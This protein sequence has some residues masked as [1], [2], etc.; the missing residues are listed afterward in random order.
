MPA[1]KLMPRD[2][3]VC[4]WAA[5][6]DAECGGTRLDASRGGASSNQLKLVVAG[7]CRSPAL[8]LPTRYLYSDQDPVIL[9][10]ARA[11]RAI[12]A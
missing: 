10:D 1:L 8:A 9:E 7:T 5:V 6:D 4:S 2:W 3:R 11:L 12:D